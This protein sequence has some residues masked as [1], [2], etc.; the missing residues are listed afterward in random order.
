MSL[1]GDVIMDRW[2]LPTGQCSEAFT[3]TIPSQ[4]GNNPISHHSSLKGSIWQSQENEQKEDLL[5]AVAVALKF[6]VHHAGF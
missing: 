2:V 6:T 5:V 3:L 4:R 1:G